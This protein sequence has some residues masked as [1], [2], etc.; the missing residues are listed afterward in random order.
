MKRTCFP[1]NIV[2]CILIS[3]PIDGTVVYNRLR[4]V[5]RCTKYHF[6]PS[7]CINPSPH[8]P[9]SR[10]LFR[11]SL[12]FLSPSTAMVIDT[13]PSNCPFSPAV[14]LTT[15]L[16]NSN[17]SCILGTSKTFSHCF[18]AASVSLSP[19]P[20]RHNTSLMWRWEQRFMPAE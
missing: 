14:N 7:I 1:Q 4:P 9:F 15:P 8:T 19:G 18:A 16:V 10:A 20:N 5:C 11:I 12:N 2:A 13:I 17:L 6:T 3:Q